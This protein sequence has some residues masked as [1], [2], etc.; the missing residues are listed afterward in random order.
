MG[1]NALST[2]PERGKGRTPSI[3]ISTQGSTHSEPLLRSPV[4]ILWHRVTGEP[5]DSFGRLVMATKGKSIDDIADLL[6]FPFEASDWPGKL[7]IGVGLLLL[8]LFMPF[9]PALAVYGYLLAVMRQVIEGKG[10]SLPE[11]EDWGKLF[12]DGLRAFVVGLVYLL[13]A[14]LVTGFGCGIYFAATIAMPIATSSGTTDP[15]SGSLFF[16]FFF[17]AIVLL[18]FC[19]AVGSVLTILGGLPLPMAEASLSETSLLKRAFA[20]GDVIRMVRAN[21]GGYIVA[22]LV[23]AGM[24]AFMYWAT[25]IVYY[26]L[27][28]ACLIPILVLPVIL[29]ALLIAAALFGEA[30]R[31]SAEKLSA[32]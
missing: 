11:W 17:A 13:P 22:W 12:L 16:M 6:T 23:L 26:T 15:N 9:I 8:S 27:V 2:R 10:A 21:P 14:I 4:G 19:L 20:I 28:L 3:H 30:Y 31:V 1:E 29:Y 32:G 5:L 24:L 7:A 25:L 18:F